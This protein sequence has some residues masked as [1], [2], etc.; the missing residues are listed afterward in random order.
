MYHMI[1]TSAELQWPRDRTT[2]KPLVVKEVN[3]EDL[4]LLFNTKEVTSKVFPSGRL[5]NTYMP[6]RLLDVNIPYIICE[7]GGAFVSFDNPDANQSHV[8]D[9]STNQSEVDAPTNILNQAITASSVCDVAMVT[10][11]YCYPTP[12]GFLYYLD[13]YAKKGLSP[14]H[15]RAHFRKNL[16]TLQRHFPNQDGKLTVTHDTNVSADDI[17]AC[18]KDHGIVDQMKGQ[19]RSQILY[20]RDRALF[21]FPVEQ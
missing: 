2:T 12:I 10:F 5:L 11:Y 6:Y 9:I 21:G 17:L 18:L 8:A 14:T 15:F 16:E 19:E 1:L 7:R 3:S 20:E 13:P 4:K